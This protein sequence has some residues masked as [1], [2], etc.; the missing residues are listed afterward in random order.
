MKPHIC[1][2]SKKNCEWREMIMGKGYCV[3]LSHD[4]PCIDEEVEMEII[5]QMKPEGKEK[6]NWFS[7]MIIGLTDYLDKAPTMEIMD[8]VNDACGHLRKAKILIKN[9]YKI[10]G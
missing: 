9:F 4:K 6:F 7:Q 10:D 8:R 1:L 3:I 5:E 2:R